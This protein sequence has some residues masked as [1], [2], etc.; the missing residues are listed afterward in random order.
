LDKINVTGNASSNPSQV[1]N[2]VSWTALVKFKAG[3]TS[4]VKYK[5]GKLDITTQV[6]GR[7]DSSSWF[8]FKGAWTAQGRLDNGQ[9]LSSERQAGHI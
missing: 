7:L 6:K 3:C 9:Q 4:L 1:Q 5:V 2:K 8:E